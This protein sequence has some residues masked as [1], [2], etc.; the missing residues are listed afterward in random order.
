MVG[1]FG[2][3]PVS[4]VGF[5]PGLTMTEL[6]LETHGLVPKLM[7]T[8]DIYIIVIG[9]NLRGAQK[10]ARQLRREKVN[11][12]LD[13]TERKIDKQLKTAIKKNIPYIMFIG[14]DELTK[15]IYPLKNTVT[16]EEKKLSLE[17]I[18]S[19]VSDRRH[20]HHDDDEVF[21]IAEL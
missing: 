14:D 12:E 19:T 17:R 18:I 16:S 20:S 1:L 21:D 15:E 11:V 8:T 9:D 13:Y 2:A 5:A 7:S 4:A 10:I 6:F 3:E